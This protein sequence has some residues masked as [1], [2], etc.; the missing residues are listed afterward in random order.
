[1]PVELLESIIRRDAQL[2]LSG[3]SQTQMVWATEVFKILDAFLN[4]FIRHVLIFDVTLLPRLPGL[5]P[6]VVK[7][8]RN[9]S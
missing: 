7:G 1:M 6:P 4:L 9:K 8:I 5:V 3:H 2:S